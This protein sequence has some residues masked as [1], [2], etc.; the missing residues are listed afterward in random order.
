M[1]SSGYNM[2]KC[3]RYVLALIALVVSVYVLASVRSLSSQEPKTPSR[4]LLAG[5][6]L[7]RTST[8]SSFSRNTS[9]TALPWSFREERLDMMCK[10]S[11]KCCS[12]QTL[13]PA[14]KR[15]LYQHILV[16]DKFK[17]LYCFVPKVACSNW[18]RVLKV[19]DGY[20][21]NS[22]WYSKMDHN[23]GLT[24]LSDL[25]EQEAEHRLEN[26]YKFTFVREPLTRLLSAYRNKFGEKFPAFMKRYGVK[27]VKRYRPNAESN[28]TGDDVTFSEYLQYLIEE[29]VNKMDMH[30]APM[31]ELCQ[32][33]AVNYDFVGT[34]ENLDADVEY[35]LKQTGAD[36]VV[37]FPNRQKYYKP[38][39]QN[40]LW[41]ELSKVPRIYI[42]DIVSKYALDFALFSY[43]VQ[44]FE[45]KVNSSHISAR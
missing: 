5:N 28:P 3:R 38:T 30:W 6:F 35:V 39:T 2:R 34:F 12:V 32:P 1:S 19:I 13:T 42:N 7:A 10:S 15:V 40:V 24:H 9:F 44:K 27:I 17:F 36:Q 33:C 45:D 23:V 8:P 14:E 41:E 4:V 29:D 22:D 18:K 37:H 21:N 16:N 31:H 43:P 26:Y 11:R 20:L 25:S